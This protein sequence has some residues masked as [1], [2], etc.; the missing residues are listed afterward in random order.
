MALEVVVLYQSGNVML[1]L[2][3]H[4]RPKKADS[5]TSSE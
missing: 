1:N 3:Q 5:E 4:L 2:F